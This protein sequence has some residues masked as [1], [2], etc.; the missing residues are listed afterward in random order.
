MGFYLIGPLVTLI[1]LGSI[2]FWAFKPYCDD[3]FL[4]ISPTAITAAKALEAACARAAKE[5]VAAAAA[6]APP[7]PSG[8]SLGPHAMSMDLH[9]AMILQEAVAL[10][11]PH[12]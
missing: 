8:S 3:G 7:E 9:A 10:L 4:G 12:A 2:S 6:I 11:N 5:R 1:P